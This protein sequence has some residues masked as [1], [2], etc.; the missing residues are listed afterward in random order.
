MEV[1]VELL[2]P[3]KLV[4]PS[5]DT[6]PATAHYEPPESVELETRVTVQSDVLGSDDSSDDSSNVESDDSSDSTSISS[7]SDNSD[8]DSD[9]TNLIPQIETSSITSSIPSFQIPACSDEE[10]SE[11]EA[12]EGKWLDSEVELLHCNAAEYL[13]SRGFESLSEIMDQCLVKRK[14]FYDHCAQGLDRTYKQVDRKCQTMFKTERKKK[15][16]DLR[17]GKWLKS[18][19]VLLKSNAEEYLES[20]HFQTIEEVMNEPSERKLFVK[21]CNEG[22]NRTYRSVFMKCKSLFNPKNHLGKYTPREEKHLLALL[23]AHKDKEDKWK[24]IGEE[25]GRSPQSVRVK[26][27]KRKS[28]GKWSPAEVDKLKEGVERF[29]IKGKIDWDRVAEFVGSRTKDDC[30]VKRK[31]LSLKLESPVRVHSTKA[32]EDGVKLIEAI[33]GLD[34]RFR[35]DVDW[36]ELAKTCPL[37]EEVGAHDL[38]TR[39]DTLVKKY[40]P[41]AKALGFSEVL[42]VLK[43]NY[44]DKMKRKVNGEKV[45][46]SN[47]QAFWKR[48][49]LNAKEEKKRKKKNKGRL[50]P[51]SLKFTSQDKLK[52]KKRFLNSAETLPSAENL[53][54]IDE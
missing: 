36:K 5:P 2:S 10:G 21:S 25:L 34:V 37:G 45:V 26:C 30:I 3:T 28:V 44:V 27:T 29:T 24:I 35:D 42:S 16:P 4:Q 51:S 12:K 40:V 15:V 38:Q 47:S 43:K 52:L 11:D 20:S 54:R 41:L 23:K 17:E 32:G 14:D 9:N 49:I 13:I 19:V 8:S 46:L 39:F 31:H 6:T 1:K 22:L 7:D 18:E 48:K 53:I 50:K 33:D